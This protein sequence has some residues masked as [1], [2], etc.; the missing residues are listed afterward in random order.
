M[1]FSTVFT[2]ALASYTLALP[3]IITP[4]STTVS[5][6]GIS[7]E[8]TPRI[9]VTLPTGSKKVPRAISG[10]IRRASKNHDSVIKLMDFVTTRAR[11][12]CQDIN[13]AVSAVKFEG[14]KN[15]AIT[16]TVDT[17]N[18]IRTLLS[19]TVSQLDTT[20]NMVFTQEERRNLIDDVHIITSEFFKAT[21]DYIETLGGASGGRSLSRAAHML[22]DVLES[23]VS[24][25][26][27]IA[28]DMSRKLKPIFSE[29]GDDDEDLLNVVM[30]SVM[31][32]VSSIETATTCGTED[33]LSDQNEELR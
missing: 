32:F 26:A 33:C 2:A 16:T 7:Q 27:G 1:K 24:I 12:E 15:E 18:T 14:L 11:T 22:T 23:I 5:N 19:E 29:V 9:G 8:F 6:R 4:D 13:V 28:S 10:R 17:M 31:S 3:I 30:S 25:D 20:P 21:Q